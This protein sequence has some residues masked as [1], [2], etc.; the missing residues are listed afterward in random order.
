MAAH[1]NMKL[2]RVDREKLT[3]SMLKIQSARTTLGQVES[4]SLPESDEIDACLQSADQTLRQALG[5]TQ[6]KGVG[7]LP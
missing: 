1:F 6:S 3:D 7:N 4:T 5:Y 2:T